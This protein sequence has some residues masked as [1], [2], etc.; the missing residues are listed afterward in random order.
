MKTPH[1]IRRQILDV[2]LHGSEAEGIALQRRL[3]EIWE[4]QV[5]PAIEEVFDRLAPDETYLFIERLEIDAGIVN[6][7]GF[8]QDLAD[9][10]TRAMMEQLAG[11]LPVPGI[12]RWDT[13]SGMHLKSASESLHEAFIY[14]LATGSLPWW[15]RLQQGM[16]FEQN[17][18]DAAVADGPTRAALRDALSSVTARVRLVRQFSQTFLDRL[19]FELAP[20]ALS[21]VHSVRESLAISQL[22]SEQR[23]AITRQLWLEALARLAAGDALTVRALAASLWRFVE[24]ERNYPAAVTESLERLAAI[25]EFRDQPSVAIRGEA[26]AG[27]AETTGRESRGPDIDEGIF[28]DNAGLVLLHPF[29]PRLFKA[30]GIAEGEKLLRPER[31]LCL[32]HYLATG[33][34]TAPEYEL[35]LPKLL[36]NVDFAFPAELDV[37]LTEQ[38]LKEAEKVLR[39]AVG[40]WDALGNTSEEGLRGAFLFRPGKLSRHED[41]DWLLQVEPRSFDILLDR[42]PWGIG[43]VKLP[44]MKRML[45]I[46]WR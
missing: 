35:L 36:C 26:D 44:W 34:R 12:S 10:V 46:D 1:I 37:G 25:R 22:P 2:E 20:D 42:I 41:G 16:S 14:F 5:A 3:P 17:L 32:L 21:A 13:S 6:S 30:L 11:K 33:H 40:H 18:F 23:Q 8:E 31:A 4:S 28:I 38:E 7:A 27:Y 15:L 43:V 45:W 19:F 29:I 39:A 24:Q 9:A